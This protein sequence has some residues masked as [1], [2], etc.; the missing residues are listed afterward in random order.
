[1]LRN[2][3]AALQ[4]RIYQ[5]VQKHGKFDEISLKEII[6]D[7]ELEELDELSRILHRAISHDRGTV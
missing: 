6:A 1:M 7:P 2:I 5:L 3:D 4:E